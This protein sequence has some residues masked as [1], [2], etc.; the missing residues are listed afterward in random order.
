M[1]ASTNLKDLAAWAAEDRGCGAQTIADGLR[2]TGGGNED[3][4]RAL[5][6]W[7]DEGR[8]VLLATV[9]ASSEPSF[10]PGARLACTDDGRMAGTLGDSGLEQVLSDSVVEILRTGTSRTMTFGKDGAGEWAIAEPGA[11][12]LLLETFLPPWEVVVVGSGKVP[13]ALSGLCRAAG[14]PFRVYDAREDAPDVAGALETVRGP[15]EEIGSRMRI[16]I[17]SHCAVAT[18]RH[19]GDESVVRQL[20]SIQAA[21]Y[22]GLMHNERKAEKLVASLRSQGTEVDG[23]FRCPIGLAI[24]NQN[25]GQIAVG[26]LA[27]ILSVANGKP[28]RPMG[29][30]WS[31]PEGGRA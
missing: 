15:W 1:S 30:D 6:K 2:R 19:E 25:P 3:P 10:G 5:V 17:G 21:P 24:A 26:I 13:D 28:V 29:I 8:A 20:L 23:R 11:A 31:E 27:E 7:R 9:V 4:L 18:P 12:A 14:I 16:G 22:V